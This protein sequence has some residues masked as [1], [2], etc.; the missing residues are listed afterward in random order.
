MHTHI[1]KLML[2]YKSNKYS[3]IHRMILITNFERV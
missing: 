1:Y 3:K 2:M